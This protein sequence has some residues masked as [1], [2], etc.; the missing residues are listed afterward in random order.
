MRVKTAVDAPSDHAPNG[1]VSLCVLSAHKEVEHRKLIRA[2]FGPFDSLSTPWLAQRAREGL[3]IVS[4]EVQ[5]AYKW[6]IGPEIE[7]AQRSRSPS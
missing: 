5:V 3:D 2:I 7:V 1:H 4:L 6:R